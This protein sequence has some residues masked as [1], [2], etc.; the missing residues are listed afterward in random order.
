MKRPGWLARTRARRG[1]THPGYGVRLGYQSVLRPAYLTKRELGHHGVIFGAPGS[2]KSTVLSLL[3]QGHSQIG[4]TIVIDGKGAPVLRESVRAAGGLVWTIGGRLKLDLLDPDP[5][6][7][8]EQLTEASRHAG[9]SE[10]YTEAAARMIQWCGYLLAWQN[11]TPTLE[12]IE[13]LMLGGALKKALQPFKARPR[14]ER[15]LAELEDMTEVELSGMRTALMRITRLIDSAAGPSLGAG[16]EAAR[17]EDVVQGRTTLLLSLDGRRYPSLS[18]IVAGWA[19]IGLQRACMAVPKKTSCLLVIDELGSFGWQ[20]KHIEPLLALARDQGV[21]VV[22]AA[23]GPTQL[24]TA[25]RG[26][27]SQVLQ[28]TAWQVVMAQGDP[29]DADRLA[30]LFPLDETKP[31]TMGTHLS[32]TPQVT[33]D[34][35]EWLAVG[36][37]YYRVRAVDSRDGRWGHARIA[38][39]YVLEMP[40]TA[41]HTGGLEE[42]LQ[43]STED[44]DATV[45]ASEEPL[46]AS[47][48]DR[49]SEEEEKAIVYR[50]VIVEDGWRMWAGKLDDDGY[51]MVLIPRSEGWSGKW[52]FYKLPAHRKIVEWEQGPIPARWEV[53][54]ECGLKRCLDHMRAKTK[55]ANLA[56]KA[57]RQRGEIPTGHAGLATPVSAG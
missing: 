38:L 41:S 11:K 8:A 42:E 14:V 57:A 36:D 44:V 1:V 56:N 4:P 7:L 10:V 15:W 55:G 35:L 18:R 48:S 24:E 16:V 22:L 3:I 17:F 40:A 45:Q 21:G 23:H 12:A 50:A 29:N 20:A 46:Q 26:L 19:L 27:A 32:G 53:D 51:P 39:P 49:R 54:H 47:P 13:N 2:G 30:M 5:T 33:R 9:P 52:K 25:H 43:A 34:D 31:Q 28:M 6:I 37:C